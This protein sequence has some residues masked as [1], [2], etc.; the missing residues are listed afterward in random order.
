[1]NI[2]FLALSFPDISKTSS[3]YGDLVLEFAAKGHHITVVAPLL[4]GNDTHVEQIKGVEVLWVK[5]RKLLNVNPIKKGIANLLLPYQYERAIAKH[6][7]TTYDLIIIPTPPITFAALAKSLKKKWH[8]KV[9]LILRD[10]FPQNAKD[11]GIIKHPLL[12]NFFRK[13]ECALYAVSDQIGCMS[14]GNI[15]F[16]EQHN[17]EVEK[18]KLHLL[19]NWGSIALNPQHAV[20]DIRKKLN[21]E[22]KFIALFGGNIGLPQ[23][24]ENLLALAERCMVYPDVCFMFVGGGTE[25]NRLQEKVQQM[26]LTNVIVKRSIPRADFEALTAACDLGLISLDQR[27]TIPNIPSK[28][29]SY[30]Q[31][32]IPVLASIDAHTDYGTLLTDEMQAGLWAQ[33]GD[34]EAVFAQFNQLYMNPSLR[35]QMGENGRLYLENHLTV[36]QACQT[37]IDKIG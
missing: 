35:K 9:Y 17:P 21:L 14:R 25:F 8:A 26:N 27:F 5:T 12:F 36:A 11:L 6:L 23:R 4:Q 15:A 24:F 28:T 10:I 32:R 16:V 18:S 20:G 22:G 31:V 19:P 30:L 34:H 3:L 29:L 7:N 13:K 37:I 33:A 2:L 1:M